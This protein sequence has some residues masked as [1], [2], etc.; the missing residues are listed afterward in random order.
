MGKIKL[1]RK[2]AL[3]KEQ[4]EAEAAMA[5]AGAG[6]PEGGSHERHDRGRPEHRGPRR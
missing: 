5:P 3:T 6:E 2:Q 4:L 1:S